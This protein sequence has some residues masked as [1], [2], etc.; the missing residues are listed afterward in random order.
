MGIT[1]NLEVQFETYPPRTIM[2]FALLAI[3]LV[4][5]VIA[6]PES[7]PWYGY[8]GLGYG[9][10][11]GYPYYGG[12]HY[13]EKRSADAEPEAKSEADPWLV[14]Y[15]PYGNGYALGH[16]GHY[17]GHYLG[18]RSAD[19]E[20]ESKPWYYAGYGGYVSDTVSDTDMVSDMAI[21]LERDLLM[22]NQKANHFLDIV[23]TVVADTDT[24]DIEDMEDTENK[25]A[26]H[27]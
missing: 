23:D 27:Y 4:A 17:Y 1:S 24:E 14:G 26:S 16:Y 22:L 8:G 2:K 12:Y 7:K 5:G 11:Y 3:A 6:E 19:A 13:L 9:Y 18:K 20:P 15:Y 10:A 25:P 21:T